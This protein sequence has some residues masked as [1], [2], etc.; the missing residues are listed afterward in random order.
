MKN[1]KKILFIVNVDWFL[2]SHR[3]PILLAAQK[4]GFDVHVAC[5][6]TE[7]KEKLAKLGF[8]LHEVNFD[9]ARINLISEIKLMFQLAKVLKKEAPSVIHLVTIKPVLYGSLLA[10]IFCRKSKCIVAISG[11]G[12]VFIAK[13]LVAEFKQKV[14]RLLYRL[15]LHRP[16]VS[17]IFQ[18]ATDQKLFLNSKIVEQHQAH[19]IKGSGVNLLN[20]S[21]ER[22][23][24]DVPVLALMARM[25]KDKGIY[26]FISAV[27]L[28]REKPLDF[29]A[30]L[31]GKVDENPQSVSVDEILEWVEDGIVEYWGFS[32]NVPETLKKVDIMV[33]P[34]YREGL[35]KSLIEAAAAGK[36]VV[37]T[38]VP[39]CRDA[40]KPNVTGFLVPL[41]DIEKLAD[42]MEYLIRDSNARE[43]MGRNGRK[44][45]EQAFSI[46]DV[47]AKHIE[48]YSLGE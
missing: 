40:I 45:A 41:K 34:S 25:L 16:S 6:F 7:N 27:K 22:T 18:N 11:L 23:G 47:I 10:R 5:K 48:L 28:L 36:V 26:E 12:Y 3:L 39:G 20:Y 13:G 30:V 4:A 46:E 35:P 37:T 14:V 24:N 2:I 9:R 31:I 42:R 17:V 43:K 32:S 15:G 8:N 29:R 21:S 44:W 1:S 38:D 19:L 33:L